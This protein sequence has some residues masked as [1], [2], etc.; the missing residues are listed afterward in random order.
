MRNDELDLEE[1]PLDPAT[2]KVRVK[3]VRL[4]GVSIGIMMIGLMA[5]LGAI[6]YKFSTSG[7]KDT[8]VVSTEGKNVDVIGNV[9][10]EILQQTLDL[11][12]NAEILDTDVNG[13]QIL[14]RL[15]LANHQE[16]WIYDIPKNAVIAKIMI[17]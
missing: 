3:M 2:E 13:A 4:L 14:M 1:K 16:L 17:K 8:A 11:P 7:K 6:I 9:P 10:G 12:E 15:K 5:V